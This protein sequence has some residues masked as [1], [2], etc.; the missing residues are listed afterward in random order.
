MSAIPR[1]APASRLHYVILRAIDLTL[2]ALQVL[3]GLLFLV[4]C[5]NKFNGG[6]V[7][8]TSIFG[9]AGANFWIEVFTK[10]GIGQW[11]RYFTGGLEMACGILLFIPQTAGIAAALLAC[12]MVGAI[13]THVLILRDGV[14][15][16]VECAVLLAINCL[17]SWSRLPKLLRRKSSSS[18]AVQ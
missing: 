12:I 11:F 4:F 8:W 16:V 1:A 6:S 15:L 3:T 10:I 13:L 14:A 18:A 5:A 17:I 9:K 7:F 2:W